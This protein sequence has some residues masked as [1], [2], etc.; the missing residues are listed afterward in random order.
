MKAYVEFFKKCGMIQKYM[1]PGFSKI[2]TSK[3]IV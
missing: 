3:K 1:G 2:L